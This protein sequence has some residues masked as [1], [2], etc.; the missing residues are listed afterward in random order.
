MF[1]QNPCMRCDAWA[2]ALSWW[3]CQSPVAHS[4]GLLNH[5]NSF[6]GGMFIL[7]QNLMQIHCSPCSVIL[8]EM[9]TQYTCS[10]RRR[11]HLQWL[12]QWRHHCSCTHIPVHLPWL[13][14]YIDVMQIILII[15]TIAGLFMYIPHAIYL[16]FRPQNFYCNLLILFI[17]CIYFI[18]VFITWL[19]CL[20]K[21]C[22]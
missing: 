3:S 6:C 22:F 13:P 2:G 21:E 20:L 10:L 9:A 11:H 5:L 14:V 18:F 17:F 8:N 16:L 12:A 1:H 7:M 15:L 19:K 4:C